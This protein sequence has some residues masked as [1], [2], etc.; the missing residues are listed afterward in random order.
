MNESNFE[1]I[2]PAL[3]ATATGGGFDFKSIFHS[4]I[5]GFQQGGIKGALK[6][7]GQAALSSLIGNL[8]GGQQQA[9]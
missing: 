5:S 1:T 7:G 6:A 4:A 3:L 8:G 9:E 2:D